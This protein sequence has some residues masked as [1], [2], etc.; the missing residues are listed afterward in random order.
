MSFPS[1]HKHGYPFICFAFFLSCIGFAV[2]SSIGVVFASITALC[3]YFFRDPVRVVPLD[4][5]LVV[6]PA[7]GVVTSIMEA[8]S[9]LEDGKT[10][11]RVSVFLSLLDVHV[12]RVPVS[13]VVKLVEHRPGSFSSANSGGAANENERVRVVIESSVGSHGIVVEQIAGVLARRIVCDLEVDKPVALGARMGI[14]R[15]GSRMNLYIP[16]EIPISV[17]EGHTVVGGETIIASLD[18]RAAELHRKLTFDKV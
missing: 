9:P 2:S 3:A 13:G 1:I 5:A 17:S 16:A 8:E 11:T 12:N 10:V 4:D 6:S 18:P 14:I 15:F 7:D